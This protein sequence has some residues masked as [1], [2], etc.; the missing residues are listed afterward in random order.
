MKVLVCFMYLISLTDTSIGGGAEVKVNHD[1]RYNFNSF[2]TSLK[3]HAPKNKVIFIKFDD[4]ELILICEDLGNDKLFLFCP[5]SIGI[6]KIYDDK[7]EPIEQDRLIASFS[8]VPGPF[9]K[10][11]GIVEN[12]F[13]I[14]EKELS[15]YWIDKPENFYIV[16]IRWQPTNEKRNPSETFV[17]IHKNRSGVWVAHDLDGVSPPDNT[18]R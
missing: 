7:M 2:Y 5:V 8:L 15:G 14:A 11:D 3:S 12:D 16:K 18:N 9:F 4:D 10:G 6:M 1:Y 13:D 17:K